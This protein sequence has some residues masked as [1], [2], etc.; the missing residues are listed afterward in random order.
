MEYKTGDIYLG[1]R[2][3]VSSILSHVDDPDSKWSEVG[4][5]VVED[6]DVDQNIDNEVEERVEY[7]GV[8]VFM[9]GQDDAELVNLE[10]LLSSPDLQA[11]AYRPL[12]VK[13]RAIVVQKFYDY[14]N[15]LGKQSIVPVSAPMEK[16]I[17]VEK[18]YRIT[19]SG[20]KVDL[21]GRDVRVSGFSKGN[22]DRKMKRDFTG[23]DLIFSVLAY[24]NLVKYD[25]EPK[26]SYF[27]QGG[28]L[29]H[30]YGSE[31]S[32]NVASSEYDPSELQ[33]LL[34][35]NAIKDA[36]KLVMSYYRAKPI[37]TSHS[38]GAKKVNVSNAMSPEHGEQDVIDGRFRLAQASNPVSAKYAKARR[39]HTTDIALGSESKTMDSK[40]RQQND[41][42]SKFER[43]TPT[44][45]P[46]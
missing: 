20:T 14:F 24:A 42:A 37:Q 5:F 12:S 32:L 26:L 40:L 35:E 39:Y 34:V 17:G 21:R 44:Y 22:A 45:K 46:K 23:P 38:E 2:W 31:V 19:S 16:A 28:Q 29:D 25:P 30:A 11:A 6:H 15:Q 10:D 9:L 13:Q 8:S 1:N 33:D 27:Q 18:K 36:E 7:S 41:Q 43:P 4:I 3:S